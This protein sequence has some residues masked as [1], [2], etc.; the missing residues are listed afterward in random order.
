MANEGI[1]STEKHSIIASLA[2][3]SFAHKDQA[4]I[5]S[6]SEDREP[7]KQAKP[8]YT[9]E[10]LSWR[11]GVAQANRKRDGWQD[12]F[13]EMMNICEVRGKYTLM[14]IKAIVPN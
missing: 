11:I 9:Q 1:E 4:L 12:V 3:K 2:I 14:I 7:V 13:D 10:Y 5:F 8:I 6:A